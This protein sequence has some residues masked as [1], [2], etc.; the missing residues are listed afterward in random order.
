LFLRVGVRPENIRLAG[1]GVPAEVRAV[2]Y[3][4]AETMIEAVVAGLPILARVSGRA[5]CA[6]G[7]TVHLAWAASATHWFDASTER[8]IE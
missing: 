8:R 2:E 7:E 4:G 5:P 3:L 1:G 6:V